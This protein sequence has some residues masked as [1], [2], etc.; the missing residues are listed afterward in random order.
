LYAAI[1]YVATITLLCD[2]PFP[3]AMAL[4][5]VVL[6]TVMMH[7]PVQDVDDVVGNVPFVV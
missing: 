2:I 5:M 4:M 7:E 3:T 6:E 1:V